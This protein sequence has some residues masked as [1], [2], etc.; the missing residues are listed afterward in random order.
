LK[1]IEEKQEEYKS[2]RIEEWNKEEDKEDQ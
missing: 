2:G 1:K